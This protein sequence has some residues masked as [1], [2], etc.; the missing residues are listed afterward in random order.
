MDKEEI[1]NERMVTSFPV[2]MSAI[3]SELKLRENMPPCI[4]IAV[5]CVPL[6]NFPVIRQDCCLYASCLLPVV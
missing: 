1:V 2:C 4:R 5:R 6:R 3:I